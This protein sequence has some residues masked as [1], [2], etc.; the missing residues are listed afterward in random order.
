MTKP[1]VEKIPLLV[2]VGPTAVGKTAFAISLA[3]ILNTDIIS[4]DSAQVYRHLDIGT[5]KPTANEQALVKHYM[6]DLVKPDQFFSAADYK[7]MVDE[8]IPILWKK[9]RLPFMVGGTGLYVD[10]VTNRYAFGEKAY[11]SEIRN[12]L[13]ERA[14]IE[15][16][17]ALYK[18]LEEIDPAAAQRIHPNDRRRILRALE[19]YQLEGKPI[20]E[21]VT[22]TAKQEPIYQT[23][24]FGL[25]MQ[26]EQLYER[27][28]RR[29][30]QMLDQGFLEEVE[31]LKNCGYGMDAPAMQILGY[32]QL[33]QYLSGK[34]SWDD[35]LN[36]IKKETRNLAKRQLTWFRR[37]KAIIWFDITEQKRVE[38]FIEN[39]CLKV[40]D[41]T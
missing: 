17:E 7:K 22:E 31:H 39:I 27:I 5:A 41:M 29:V 9:G 1:G 34:I 25:N 35:T 36:A 28:N 4:S 23:A 2:L 38:E 12:L 26:R 10:A 19:V 37:N 15:G 14:E 8:L 33:Y 20:S 13:G 6:I 16:L 21:Q 18:E 3:S 32:R 24:Y 30:E 11:S 40:K